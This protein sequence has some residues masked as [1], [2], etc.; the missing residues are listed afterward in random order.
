MSRANNPHYGKLFKLI[1]SAVDL[2]NSVQA[3]VKKSD[4]T[5]SDPTILALSKF[6]ANMQEVDKLLD[7]LNN[8]DA[9]AGGGTVQ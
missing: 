8:I 4:A 6:R 1:M 7:I 3:D 5:I 9:K 2:A